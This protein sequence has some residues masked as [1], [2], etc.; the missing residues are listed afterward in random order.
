M[1]LK[2]RLPQYI[3]GLILMAVG[4]VLI[5]RAALG[6]SPLSAIPDA[7]AN[8]TPFTLGNM[9]IAFHALCV[10]MQIIVEKRVTLKTVLTLPLA[11]AFGYVI[12][13]FMLLI[14]L[15]SDSLWLRAAACFGGIVVTG[16][17]I[18]MIVGADL[19]L[20]APD[21]FLRAVSA[22][23]SQPLSRVKTVGDVVWVVLTIAIDLI[24]SGRIISVGIGTV[25]SALLTGKFVG[26]WNSLLPGLKME[27]T[28]KA[29]K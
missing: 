1:N 29:S 11:V 6:I 4:V 8:I 3:A 27:P 16:L 10:L 9:T 24:F 18:V 23:Y 15:P 14:A 19:M 5:K 17:G 13:L 22:T 26:W 2:R 25:F 7:V 12:D 20:P 28:S 21:A